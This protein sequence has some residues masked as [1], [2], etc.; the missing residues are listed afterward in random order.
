MNSRP[1][2]E[3][4]LNDVLGVDDEAF[5]E[6]LFGETLRVAGRRR[7]LRQLR[8]G[9]SALATLVALALVCWRTIPPR[10]QAQTAEKKSYE[11]I[12]TRPLPSVMMVV[13][14]PLTAS[15]I[16]VSFSNVQIIQ[17]ADNHQSPPEL[18]DRELLSLVG[19]APAALVRNGEHTAQLIFLNAADEERFLR[20]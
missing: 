3:R 5:R 11:V 6:S 13:S 9:A 7:R 16:V 18:D 8:L 20:N 10:P 1:E 14:K 12:N 2:N 17:T 19:S 4:L 15:E